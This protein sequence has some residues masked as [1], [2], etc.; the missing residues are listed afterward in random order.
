MRFGCCAGLDKYSVVQEIG[1]DYIELSVSAIKPESSH[2]EYEPVLKEI[3]S[4]DMRPEVWNHLL[5]RDMR[6]AGPEVDIY[7][8]E[9]YL[10][11]AFE[12]I[13]EL[14]GQIA[15]F[16]NKEYGNIPNGFPLDEANSQLIEFV[17]MAG[18]IAGTHGIT[19][20]LEPLQIGE[21]NLAHDLK[22][23]MQI[24]TS[25]NHPFVKLAAD[26]CQ[27][28]RANISIQDFDNYK[29]NIVHY[30]AQNIDTCCVGC[31]DLTHK[32]LLNSLKD[33]GY[34]GRISVNA[35]F[36]DFEAEMKKSLAALKIYM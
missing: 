21:A 19:I 18:Q 31:E 23:A 29:D 25:A 8:I 2:S 22:S 1:Y 32:A 5:A 6:V 24:I 9:R 30:Y 20:A 35:D 10:R 27:I 34:N 26:I 12:R 28:T 16:G 14:G 33:T 13:E 15:V 3:K 4:Y 36:T 17:D 7:R 11:T